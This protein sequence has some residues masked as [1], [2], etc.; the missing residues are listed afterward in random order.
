MYFFYLFALVSRNVFRI[1]QKVGNGV[2]LILGSSLLTLLKAL[3]S[4]F[5]FLF[6]YIYLH[7]R[8]EDGEELAKKLPLIQ[9]ADLISVLLDQLSPPSQPN[10]QEEQKPNGL[11]AL[12][13]LSLGLALAALKRAPVSLL[14]RAEPKTEL[15]DQ[16][17]MLVDAAID[18]G[19][20]CFF[21]ILRCFPHVAR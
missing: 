15:L 10:Q 5:D 14:R 20:S 13:Q 9:D 7:Y 12:C 1:R 11:R 18:G 21:F 19:V 3:W 2:Y 4:W 16:D 17:E 6:F 8:R